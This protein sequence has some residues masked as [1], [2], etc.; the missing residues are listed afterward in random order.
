MYK[1]KSIPE[2]DIKGA[3]DDKREKAV[4]WD[5]NWN[6]ITAESIIQNLEKMVKE[7]FNKK[8]LDKRKTQKSTK[9]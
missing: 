2:Y 3:S 5:F 4:N 1:H 6:A 8:V 9:S 7:E